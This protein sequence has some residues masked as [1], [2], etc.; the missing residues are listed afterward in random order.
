MSF[1]LATL[2]LLSA[3]IGGSLL[4]L[5]VL[6]SLLGG[7]ADVDFDTDVD[8]D[9]AG[10]GA[11]GFRTV[12]AF[13]TF[14]GLGGLA[15]RE[16]GLSD[17]AALVV[18]LPAGALAFWL[19]AFVMAQFQRL[20]SSGN[21]RIQNALGAE[22][23]VYLRVPSEKSG[24]GKVTVALQGRTHQFRAVTPG[25]E[26]ATGQMC[27]VVALHGEDALEVEAL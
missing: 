7:D 4:V 24:E 1:D 17:G 18:A 27:R 5:Q 26:I 3:L 22:G 21:L 10:G 8:T 15:A 25:P 6:I 13:V 20:R 2:Y 9:T 11:L 16:G 19:A 23:T 14:F 12:V